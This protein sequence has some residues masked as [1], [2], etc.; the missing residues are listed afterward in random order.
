MVSL[1]SNKTLRHHPCVLHVA[2]VCVYGEDWKAMPYNEYTKLKT[3]F[4]YYL[5]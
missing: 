5:D 1:H 3:Y 2:I 4:F